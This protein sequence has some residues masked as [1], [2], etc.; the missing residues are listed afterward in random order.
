MTEARLDVILGQKVRRSLMAAG[1][2]GENSAGTE[3]ESESA[4]VSVTDLS[5]AHSSKPTCRVPLTM[6]LAKHKLVESVSGR[7]NHIR[8]AGRS[9]QGSGLDVGVACS[10]FP[11]Q[12]S[13]R[14]AYFEIRLV[15]CSSPQSSYSSIGIVSQQF[16]YVSHPG[17]EPNSYGFKGNDGKKWHNNVS[18]PYSSKWKEADVIGCGFDFEK[19]CVFLGAAFER[20]PLTGV[21]PAV[22]VHDPH[23]IVEVNF[24]ASADCPFT[25]D[26]TGYV[27]VHDIREK[28]IQQIQ[29]TDTPLSVPELHALI[30]EHLLHSGYGKTYSAFKAKSPQDLEDRLSKLEASIVPRGGFEQ[31]RLS[32]LNLEDT[33]VSRKRKSVDIQHED[34]RS[35]KNEIIDSF[36]KK[37]RLNDGSS[38]AYSQT[39]YNNAN[40][41]ETQA[42]IVDR[43]STMLAKELGP[44]YEYYSQNSHNEDSKLALQLLELVAG[45]AAYDNPFESPQNH[46]LL[47]I[48]RKT[49]A[50]AINSEILEYTT[51]NIESEQ[52][53]P[54]NYTQLSLLLRQLVLT[55]VEIRKPHPAPK[56]KSS[57]RTRKYYD[58]AR[59]NEWLMRRSIAVLGDV[60][61]E[62]DDVDFEGSLRLSDDGL[63]ERDGGPS[64]SATVVCG[65]E[66]I[67]S[68]FQL[69]F[70]EILNE[71]EIE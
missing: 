68:R 48:Q 53:Q 67:D 6:K 34:V 43:I 27:Q 13:S 11:F 24:G 36:G 64:L 19:S 42:T 14:F 58:A 16:Q 12:P 10:A 2:L 33:L 57:R 51:R 38:I 31:M 25:F 4:P 69:G 26:F 65:E 54:I 66:S 20:I 15:K 71:F 46:L 50:N 49:L 30:E 21:Y 45:L 56:P 52:K 32:I 29:I 39:F 18:S 60:D 55:R 59:N 44:F 47:P 40:N 35:E 23:E 7:E 3:I 70:D 37:I 22:G 63:Y 61:S 62:D 8:F 5:S 17:A 9:R 28:K 41:S 1:Q